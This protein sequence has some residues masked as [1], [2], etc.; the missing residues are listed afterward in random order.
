MS[1]DESAGESAR[2]LACLAIMVAVLAGT[3]TLVVTLGTASGL[4]PFVMLVA[5]WNLGPYV[6]LAALARSVRRSL[7]ASAIAFAGTLGI[8]GFGLWVLYDALYVHLD[9]QSALVF[10]FLPVWQWPAVGLV[11]IVTGIVAHRAQRMRGRS[12]MP[13]FP[14]K[15][16]DTCGP[17]RQLSQADGV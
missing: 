7:L 10:I 2:A 6:V 15:S 8:C 5:A 9:P 16:G 11:C 3:A 13:A 17:S 1:T 14:V 4:S 12:R